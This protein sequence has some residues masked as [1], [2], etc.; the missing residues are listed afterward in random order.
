MTVMDARGATAQPAVTSLSDTVPVFPAGTNMGGYVSLTGDPTGPF[1]GQGVHFMGGG[2]ELR[3]APLIYR[4]AVD[5]PQCVRV[6]SVVV[7][8]A[9]FWGPGNEL[10]LLD[11]ALRP[12]ASMTTFGGNS[13]TVLT[14]NVP[15]TA[16]RRFYLEEYDTSGVWRWRSRITFNAVPGTGCPCFPPVLVTPMPE[17]SQAWAAG[18]SYG[19]FTA[20]TADVRGAWFSRSVMYPG[21]LYPGASTETLNGGWLVQRFRVTADQSIT[22]VELTLSGAAFNGPGAVVRLLDAGRQPLVSWPTFGGSTDQRFSIPLGSPRGSTFYVD[23][24]DGSTTWRYRRLLAL[25]GFVPVLGPAW[26]RACAHEPVRFVVAA[27]GPGPFGYAWQA[28]VPGS[29]GQWV[30]IADGP[31]PDGIVYAGSAT[32]TLL[33][34]PASTFGSAHPRDF[35]CIVSSGCGGVTTDPAALD[36]CAGDWNCDG[37]ADFNDFLAFLND[38]NAGVPRA[39]L[40]GDG[41][42]DFN[43]FLAFLNAFNEPC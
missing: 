20:A 12:V 19:G 4:Y 43:D 16:G 8:G 35:R 41:T 17:S 32:A 22:P 26:A 27:Q 39:D 38:Y 10:R 28:S 42:I 3:G 40:N 24:F 36:V 6:S 30:S 2:S 5:F 18:T 15:N 23:E 9:A 11:E 1:I 13:F 7:E 31:T 21:Y 29:P 34:A 33:V 14:L 37:T 25:N